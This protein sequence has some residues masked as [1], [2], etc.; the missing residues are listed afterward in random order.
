MTE[1]VVNYTA[2]QTVALV[3]AYEAVEGYEAEQA[4]V[5]E[6]AEKFGKS[7]GSVIAKLGSEGVYNAKA[8]VASKASQKKD[9][10]VDLIAGLVGVEAETFDSLAKANKTVLVKIYGRLNALTEQAEAE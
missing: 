4:I 7:K 6:F 3:E 2:E 9:E 5:A 1:K 10:I 8:K